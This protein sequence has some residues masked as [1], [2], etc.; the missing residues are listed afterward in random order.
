MFGGG[1]E[2]PAEIV[3]GIILSART[4]NDCTRCGAVMVKKVKVKTNS[5][6]GET[7]AW[8]ILES[9]RIGCLVP[10]CGDQVIEGLNM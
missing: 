2:V 9:A 1:E 7:A 10:L 8:I 3:C 6:R 4:A 5:R